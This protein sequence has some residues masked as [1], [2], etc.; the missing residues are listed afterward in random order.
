MAK[1]FLPTKLQTVEAIEKWRIAQN[2]HRFSRRLGASI[3]GSA[4][5]RKVWLSFR[6]SK[7]EDFDG[8]MLRLFNTG[9]REEERFAEELRGIGCEV[10][11]SDPETGNQFEFTACGGHFVDKIDGMVVGLPDAPKTWHTCE[12][13]THSDKSFSALRSGLQIAKPE[14]YTQLLVGMHLTGSER[15]LYLAVNKDTDEL[16]GE[17]IEYKKAEAENWMAKA[18]RL[19]QATTPPTRISD[20]ADK[21]PCKFCNFKQV[22]HGTTAPSPGV[23]ALANCRTCCHA[24][25][26]TGESELGVWRCEKHGKVL[27]EA[28]QLAGCDDHLFIP[29]FITFADVDDAGE[30]WIKYRNKDGG[31]EWV[32]ANHESGEPYKSIELTQLPAVLVGAGQVDEVKRTLGGTVVSDYTEV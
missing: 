23:A 29:D 32:N 24:T 30:D 12:F 31:A 10:H 17:R 26:V 16:Y 22:C 9:H 27:S 2:P 6:W 18:I 8:R 1:I 14:H 25:P 19:I 15:G 3:L 21:F 7:R 20:S 5:E 11:L 4:C 13:K 28:D